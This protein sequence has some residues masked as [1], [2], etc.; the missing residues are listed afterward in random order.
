MTHEAAQPSTPDL[1][2]VDE[3]F[4]ALFAGHGDDRGDY[5]KHVAG[6]AITRLLKP[7]YEG[8]LDETE[9]HSMR[10]SARILELDVLALSAISLLRQRLAAKNE[11]DDS[12]FKLVD[13]AVRQRQAWFFQESTRRVVDEG[14]ETS[15][16]TPLIV[17]HHIF[18]LE[19][20]AEMDQS[21]PGVIESFRDDGTY[22]TRSKRYSL[23]RVAGQPVKDFEDLIEITERD[24]YKDIVLRLAK[25]PNEFLGSMSN[26]THA[27]FQNVFFKF[28]LPSNSQSLMYFWDA[29]QMKDGKVV[30]LT[31]EY[32]ERANIRREVMTRD[33]G[34]RSSSGCPVRHKNGQIE[35]ETDSPLIVS[36]IGY[37][38]N[39][40][41]AARDI[42]S[43]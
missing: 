25:G 36:A 19:R 29:Y 32:Y 30:G 18:A 14:L 3:E 12:G 33:I 21:S 10:F 24:N 22:M 6:P 20:A 1:N 7:I 28:A 4:M 37:V 31:K 15:V 16:V 39:C 8:P 43:D 11:A 40:L 41:R 34:S 26:S 42:V 35:G 9:T 13:L 38:A 5:M 27:M 23:Q 2:I 17:G